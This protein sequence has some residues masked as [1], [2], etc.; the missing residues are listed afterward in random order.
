VTEVF[1]LTVVIVVGSVGRFVLDMQTQIANLNVKIHYFDLES[2]DLCLACSLL[3]LHSFHLCLDCSLLMLN[4]RHFCLA[5]SGLLIEGLL[6]LFK[7]ADNLRPFC[8]LNAGL[9]FMNLV[10]LSHDGIRVWGPE[11]SEVVA[12]KVEGL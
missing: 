6:V 9:S 12:R 3:I 10:V 11:E 4:S 1:Y 5:C 8:H 7:F 2:L